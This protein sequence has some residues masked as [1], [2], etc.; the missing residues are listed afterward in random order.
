MDFLGEWTLRNGM[1]AIVDCHTTGDAYL[2]YVFIETKGGE[3]LRVPT[4]WDGDGRSAIPWFDLIE[5]KREAKA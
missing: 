1:R 5:R 4:Y 2:G 3:T